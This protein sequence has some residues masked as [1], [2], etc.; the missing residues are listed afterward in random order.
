MNHHRW[1]KW[2]LAGVAGKT[3]E[4]LHIGI[5]S[6]LLNGLLIGQAQPLLDEE[7]TKC[8][9]HRLRWVPVLG[10]N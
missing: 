8:Q 2:C 1:V 9:S 4:K 6:D 10:L 7:R 5:F 3:Q